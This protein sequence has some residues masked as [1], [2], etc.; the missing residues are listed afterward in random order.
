MEL[1]RAL[2]HVERLVLVVVDMQRRH[3]ARCAHNLDEAEATLRLIAGDV[4]PR[5]VMQEPER[6]GMDPDMW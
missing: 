6:L 1:E 5:E 3:V 4:N 2:E